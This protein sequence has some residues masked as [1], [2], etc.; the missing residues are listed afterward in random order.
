M[1]KQST[2]VIVGASL[3]GATAAQTLREEGF[4]GR[5]VLVGDETELP[6]ER[7]PLS[8]GYLLGKDERAKIYVHEESWYAEHAVELVLGRHVTLVDREAHEVELDTG[9][10]IGYAKLLLATGASPRH[11]RVPGSELKGVHHLRR[12]EDSD[13]LREAFGAGGR[14]VVVGA[15]WIG[16]ETAA[17]ARESG[18]DVTVV[19]PQPAPL[20]AALGSEMGAFFAGLHLRNGVDLR[21]SHTVT[22]FVGADRVTSVR[23][24]AG[25][26]EAEAVVVGIGAIPNVELAERADLSCDNGIVVDESLCTQDPDIYAVG[27]VAKSYHP[28]YGAHLRTEHWANALHGAPVAAKGML[29]QKVAYDRLPYFFTDQ[30]DVGMEFCGWIGPGGYDQLVT[31]GDVHGQAFHAFWLSGDQVVAGMH[32]NRWDVGIAPVEDLIRSRRSVDPDRLA[33]TSVPLAAHVLV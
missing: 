15:G 24:D 28:F 18:C 8:K 3:A 2:Y 19:D 31:R 1:N 16:L 4:A 21:V 10:R 32:V 33:D 6:Y 7:P 20:L 29:G 27:D 5:I 25:R 17:A 23:T 26:F 9:E 14:I 22:E 12:A 11:L 30:Y 13:R